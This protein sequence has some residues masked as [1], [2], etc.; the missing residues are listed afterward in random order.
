[1]PPQDALLRYINAYYADPFAFSNDAVDEL[2]QYATQFGVPFTPN[3]DAEEKKTS[4]LGGQLFGGF[5]EGF[6]GPALPFDVVSDPT[7][8]SQQIARSIGGLVGFVPGILGGPV[9]WA[10]AKVAGRGIKYISGIGKGLEAAGSVAKAVPSV[11]MYLGSKATKAGITKLG[12]ASATAD[13][14]FKS[15]SNIH[16]QSPRAL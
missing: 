12:K 6:L 2:E 14:F 5:L 13:K 4:S 1:M 11:P 8:E 10:G 7:T 15:G 16:L 3:M 9:K